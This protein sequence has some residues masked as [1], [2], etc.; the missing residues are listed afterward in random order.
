MIRTFEEGEATRCPSCGISGRRIGTSWTALM[1]R[2]V[3]TCVTIS[4]DVALTRSG[5]SM[6]GEVRA[7]AIGMT[8]TMFPVSTAV[9][10]WTC[11]IDRKAW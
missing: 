1:F 2:T 10:P 11:R 8:R 4:S 7:L 6:E 5:R 3:M 9:K